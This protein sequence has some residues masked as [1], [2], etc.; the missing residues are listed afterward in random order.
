VQ[1]W[2]L[3]GLGL[4]LGTIKSRV[5]GHHDQAG[6]MYRSSGYST[7]HIKSKLFH[8]NSARYTV[9]IQAPIYNQVNGYHLNSASEIQNKMSW[10]PLKRLPMHAEFKFYH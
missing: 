7:G 4:L 3:A 8:L 1:Q 2:Q 5:S 6:T 9:Y 10:T